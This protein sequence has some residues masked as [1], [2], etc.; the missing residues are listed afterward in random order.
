MLTFMC[1]LGWALAVVATAFALWLAS[2]YDKLGVDLDEA[3]LSERMAKS[4]MMVW[5]DKAQSLEKEIYGLS[6][7]RC[8]E[9]GR[10]LPHN[11][12]GNLCEVCAWAKGGDL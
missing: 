6:D 12:A 7:N 9:C 3:K 2:E 5:R 11:Q 1:I 4:F 8:E 10:F